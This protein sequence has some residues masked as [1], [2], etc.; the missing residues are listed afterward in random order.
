MARANIDVDLPSQIPAGSADVRL[1]GARMIQG[2]GSPIA[3]IAYEVGGGT[4]TLLV[5]KKR[6]AGSDAAKP[7]HV[8]SPAVTAENAH[9]TSWKMREQEY[10]IASSAIHDPQLACRLCHAQAQL[11]VN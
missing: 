11:M 7:V 6:G 2:Q 4:A 8:F 1:L 10:T 9:V 5:S 3:A